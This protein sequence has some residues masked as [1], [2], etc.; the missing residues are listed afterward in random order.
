MRTI[1][2]L[3]AIA[4]LSA[5]AAAAD[6]TI[7][8]DRFED[9]TLGLAPDSP[10]VGG[11]YYTEGGTHVVLSAPS[12]KLLRSTCAVADPLYTDWTTS[13]P[14][15]GTS[16]LT[17]RATLESGT[18]LHANDAYRHAI[19][20]RDESGS[21]G[22][23]SIS[24]GWDGILRRNT[25]ITL[26]PYSLDTE[27]TFVWDVDTITDTYSLTVSGV[28][29]VDQAA[30]GDPIA[31]L[32]SFNQA[33]NATSEV[34]AQL[35]EIRAVSGHIFSS[36]FDLGSPDEWSAY[37]P[38]ALPGD[39]C[40]LPALLGQGIDTPGTLAGHSGSSGDDTGA[41][42]T[43]DTIDRWMLYTAQCTGTATIS[44][45]L[46]ATEFDTVL[47]AWNGCGGTQLAC[48]DDSVS[49]PT[50]CELSGLNR[51]SEISF[52]VT[53]GA[54]YPVRVSVYNDSFPA[55]DDKDFG[56]RVECAPTE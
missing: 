46:A 38:A 19:S 34:A 48:N 28:K 7:L 6:P 41:C 44:T 45:C 37:A 8:L 54:T 15:G 40:A 30:W 24:W 26:G 1:A 52:A 2:L 36:G 56:I 21:S 14:T 47:A 10:D 55:I 51:K 31:G 50:E 16:R 20:L 53:A 18:A 49:A 27:Y 5:P 32:Q 17:Y 33:A 35:D 4:L 12:G 11:A 29:L 25:N 42:G 39:E 43:A 3:T 23:T 9:D 13:N 22:S